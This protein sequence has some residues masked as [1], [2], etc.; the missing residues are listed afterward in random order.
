MTEIPDRTDPTR[1]T[2]RQVADAKSA[3]LR[4][5]PESRRGELKHGALSTYDDGKLSLKEY[6]H[7]RLIEAFALFPD[8]SSQNVFS[9][10]NRVDIHATAFRRGRWMAH[11]KELENRANSISRTRVGSARDESEQR[12]SDIDDSDIFPEIPQRGD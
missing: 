11:L 2:A 9:A 6:T 5:L 12:H 10:T 4:A 3:A 7:G 8:G 1:M